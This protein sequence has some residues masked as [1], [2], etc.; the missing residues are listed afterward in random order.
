LGS[1]ALSELPDG[2]DVDEARPAVMRAVRERFRPE[3]LNRL[4]EVVLFGRL[5]REN[6]AAIVD[7]QLARLRSLLE[8]RQITLEVDG[9]ALTWLGEAGYDPIYGARPLKRVIQRSVQDH[10]ATLLLEGGVHDGDV[11]H[12]GADSEG[13]TFSSGRDSPQYPAKTLGKGMSG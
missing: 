7:I 9:A 12:L 11:V 10:L 2:A 13:L 3:F 1:Q 5:A 4:D 8:A 6:M